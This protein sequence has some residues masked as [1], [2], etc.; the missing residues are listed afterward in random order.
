MLNEEDPYKQDQLAE[1]IQSFFEH[2][3]VLELADEK[4]AEVAIKI[5]HNAEGDLFY[6]TQVG[7]SAAVATFGLLQNSVAVVIGAMLIAPLLRP[8]QGMAFGIATGSGHQFWRSAKLLL[9]SMVVSIVMAWI[10]TLVIP[11]QSDTAEILA[12]TS[13]NLLDLLIAIVSSVVAFLALSYEELSEG[14]AGVAMATALMP[15]LAVVGIEIAFANAALAWGS[16]FLFLTNLFAIVLVGTVM[17]FSYGFSPHQRMTQQTTIRQLSVLLGLGLMITIPLASS[18]LN[19]SDGVR[20]QQDAQKIIEEALTETMPQ[21]IFSE[22][23][24]KRFTKKDIDLHGIIKLP[25]G[26]EFFEDAQESLRTTLSEQL[27]RNVALDL[28]VIR[29][30]SIRARDER[31]SVDQQIRSI[32]REVI[33]TKIPLA[34]IVKIDVAALSSEEEDEQLRYGVKTILVIPATVTFSKELQNSIQQRVQSGVASHTLSFFWNILPG[35]GTTAEKIS[36]QDLFLNELI[37]NW[38]G[39]LAKVVPEDGYIENFQLSWEG[40]E[41]GR[42]FNKNSITKYTVAFDLYLPEGTTWRATGIREKVGDFAESIFE[43]PADVSFRVFSYSEQ[44]ISTTP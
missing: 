11:I 31:A 41:S 28:E 2:F 35:Q 22:L 29:T 19:I 8:I 21:A 33:L 1:R 13:P 34:T 17:F 20:L 24:L 3:A 38:D 7:L 26:I 27:H 37:L 30:A 44:S 12:R 16:A 5:D 4:K 25:E 15:P 42:G 32:L 39:L 6:W 10:A 23:E 18:L 9:T 40:D 43:K 36:E 14:I